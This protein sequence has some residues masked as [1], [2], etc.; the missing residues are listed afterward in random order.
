MTLDPINSFHPTNF[1][2]VYRVDDYQDQIDPK[3]SRKAMQKYYCDT[4]AA[5]CVSHM[6]CPIT[7]GGVTV[8]TP[9][10]AGS[11][12]N[13][14]GRPRLPDPEFD[15]KS[16]P[17]LVSNVNEHLVHMVKDIQEAVNNNKELN[18]AEIS[19]LFLLIT[20]LKTQ[21]SQMEDGSV[22]VFESI[23]KNQEAIRE[24]GKQYFS[25]MDD[26]IER[27]K[28]SETLSWVSWILTGAL[29]VGGI[30]SIVLTWGMAVGPVVAA[31][32][33]AGNAIAAIGSGGLNI[34]RGVYD[35]QTNLKRG[36][37]KEL[38]FMRTQKDQKISIGME[39]MKHS[40]EVVSTLMQEMVEVLQNQYQASIMK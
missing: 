29:I 7:E 2:P 5:A 8:N 38:E 11:I 13:R 28:T 12:E 39:E 36:E 3:A 6:A 18:D 24:L 14:G 33:T 30:A 19:L 10:I 40:V 15:L 4:I 1:D 26:I 27:S 20:C 34:G 16:L 31:C 37:M 25:Q 17:T 9:Q 22:F 35:Y 21:K 23:R 32:L